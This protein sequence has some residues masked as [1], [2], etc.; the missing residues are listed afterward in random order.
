M[1]FSPDSYDL[2]LREERYRSLETR[3]RYLEGRLSAIARGN[4]LIS[5]AAAH[6]LLS[7]THLDTTPA[8]PAE[9]DLLIG[10]ATQNWARLG[11]ETDDWVLT[12]V[13]GSPAWKAV[14]AVSGGLGSYLNFGSEPVTGQSYA[15]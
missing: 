7:E 6:G 8:G 14:V 10:G 13:T 12:L 2:R 4:T 15:P 9:G 11:R 1:S 3:V 5:V